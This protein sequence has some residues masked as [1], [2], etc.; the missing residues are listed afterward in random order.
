MAGKLT[1]GRP[2]PD[3]HPFKGGRIIFGAKPPGSSAKPSTPE[4]P[5]PS[6]NSPDDLEAQAFQDYEQALSRSISDMEQRRTGQAPSSESTTPASP[7]A[8]S[9][10]SSTEQ[11]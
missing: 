5:K 10:E 9:P 1:H 4:E 7:E 11:E 3:G 6:S 2:F 8:A